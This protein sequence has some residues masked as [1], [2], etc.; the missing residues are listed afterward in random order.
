[1]TQQDLQ[2]QVAVITGSARGIG[3]EIATVLAAAGARVVICDIDAE[4]TKTTAAELAADGAETLA[5][6]CNVTKKADIESLIQTV[7]DTYGKIDIWVNNAGITRDNLMLRMKEE[8]WDLVLDINLKGTF[9]CSQ[10][11]SKVMMKQRSGKIVNIASVSGV[12]GTAGQANYAASKSGVIGLTK[13]TAREL[14]SRGVNCNAI[15]PGFIRTDMTDKLAPEVQEN[16]KKQIPLGRFGSTNDVA[17]AVHFL[18]S[19][20]SDYIT[21]QVLS[22]CGGLVM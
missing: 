19:S 5:V 11:I 4:T 22:V 21:G 10:A 7:T 6:A 14:A 17:K 8:D 13:V 16:Y 3:K 1:M 18:C 9:L 12:L 2:D 15:T 20:E